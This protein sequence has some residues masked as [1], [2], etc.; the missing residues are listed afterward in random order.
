MAWLLDTNVISEWRKPRRAQK[1]IDFLSSERRMDLFVSAVTFA[2]IRFGA[3]TVRDE[4][5]REGILRWLDDELRPFFDQTT[6]PM[7]EDILLAA[8]QLVDKANRH[9]EPMPQADA[10]IAA[11]AMV[12]KLVVVTRNTADFVT[13]GIPLFNPWTGER[14]GV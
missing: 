8:L 10:W 6:L 14:R 12:H 1:V 4:G 9:R 11:S 5:R 2:E 13:A 3:D 7:S